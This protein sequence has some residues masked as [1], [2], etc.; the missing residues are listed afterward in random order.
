[1]QECYERENAGMGKSVVEVSQE[2]EAL[3]ILR[4]LDKA[5]ANGEDIN[6]FRAEL[7]AYVDGLIG[8]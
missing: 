6:E 1:M 7:D 4:M 5:I 8:K 2:A 3:R